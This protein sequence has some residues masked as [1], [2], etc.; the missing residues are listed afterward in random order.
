MRKSYRAFKSGDD[1]LAIRALEAKRLEKMR[2]YLTVG[3]A[4]APKSTTFSAKSSSPAEKQPDKP[5]ERFL[6]VKFARRGSGSR[7]ARNDRCG[8]RAPGTGL[9]ALGMTS[10]RTSSS[11]TQPGESGGASLASKAR[12]QEHEETRIT[13]PDAW[14][15]V[16]RSAKALGRRCGCR[17]LRGPRL[18]SD[19]W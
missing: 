19:D 9:A 4:A 17:S 18:F 1:L 6:R 3:K 13:A 2:M 8:R 15:W 5:Q 16:D 10:G 14:A 7:H 11:R 12:D